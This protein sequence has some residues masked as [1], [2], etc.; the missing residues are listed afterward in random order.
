MLH[1]EQRT[2]KSLLTK[3][4]WQSMRT[5]SQ[6]D[7]LQNGKEMRWNHIKTASAM[8]QKLRGA[9][10][11]LV[12]SSELKVEF[13]VCIYQNKWSVQLYSPPYNWTLATMFAILLLTKSPPN[14]VKSA[15]HA[16]SSKTMDPMPIDIIAVCQTNDGSIFNAYSRL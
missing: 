1:T 5:T 13:I 4:Q 12:S 6:T 11:D 16:V 2:D 10:L 9:M 3:F 8:I 14:K 7:S 15:K